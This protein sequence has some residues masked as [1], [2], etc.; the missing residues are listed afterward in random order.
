MDDREILVTYLQRIYELA[1]PIPGR[2]RGF[3]AMM[4]QTIVDVALEGLT[5]VGEPPQP[6]GGPRALII[7]RASSLLK[8]TKPYQPATPNARPTRIK[9]AGKQPKQMTR[10]MA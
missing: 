1:R 2:K 3:G 5:K 9:R 10:S 6:P 8:P 7:K 4:R